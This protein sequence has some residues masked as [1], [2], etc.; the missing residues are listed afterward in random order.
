MENRPDI[1]RTQVNIPP[2]LRYTSGDVWTEDESYIVRRRNYDIYLL[3]YTIGGEGRLTYGEREYPLT[4]GTA[5]LIDCREEQIYRTAR[6][7]WN[8]VFIHFDTEILKGYVDRLCFTHG[9]VFRLQDGN[10]LENLMRAAI[11]I[12]R[13]DS[14]AALHRTFGLL[15]EI[16][17]LLYASAEET[18]TSFR[19]SPQTEAVLRLIDR[20]C[21]DR[22][23]LDEIARQVGYSKYYLAH[24]FK[25]DMG[26]SVYEYLTLLRISKSKLLLLNTNLSV[27]DIASGVGFS[28]VSNFIRTFSQYE[29]ITPHKYRKQWQ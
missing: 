19:I 5:F 16:L 28:S 4:P 21:A 12:F 20:R 9:P 24:H 13:E 17:S 8:F 14:P 2:P 15:A 18:E 11:S 1:S 29:M 25:R 22:L 10:T 6:E 26:V 23:T 3:L 27:A 7:S